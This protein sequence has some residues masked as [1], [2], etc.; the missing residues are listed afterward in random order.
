[1]K[2]APFSWTRAFPRLP[3]QQALRSL[4]K[5]PFWAGFAPCAQPFS[6]A[7]VVTVLVPAFVS[8][9]A[10]F[11]TVLWDTPPVL[12]GGN[13]VCVMTGLAGSAAD[14]EHLIKRPF[15]PRHGAA[16]A[17]AMATVRD[18]RPSS[19]ALVKLRKVVIIVA[20]YLGSG[21]FGR[22]SWLYDPRPLYGVTDA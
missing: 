6:G 10:V 11:V 7:T 5:V 4:A 3:A 14:I 9:T 19:V 13:A 17:G 15:G 20:G 8:T 21:S 16:M 1:M 12:T 2:F 18:V 22:W